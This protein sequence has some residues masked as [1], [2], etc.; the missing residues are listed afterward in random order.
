MAAHDWREKALAEY[1]G[2]LQRTYDL[3]GTEPS[4]GVAYGK[5]ADTIS[6]DR[7]KM[8]NL[9]T[10]IETLGILHTEINYNPMVNGKRQMGRQSTWQLMVPIEEARARIIEWDKEGE[11][12]EYEKRPGYAPKAPVGKGK[13]TTKPEVLPE[14]AAEYAENHVATDSLVAMVE[15]ESRF[16]EEPPVTIAKSEREETRAI[17]GPE[18]DKTFAALASLRKDEPAALV[19][20]ARQYS[21]RQNAVEKQYQ[22]LVTMGLEVDKEKFLSSISLPKDDLLDAISLVLPMI[23]TLQI[24]NDSLLTQLNTARDKIK[25]Y[26]EIK[27]NYERLQKRWNERVAERVA[28]A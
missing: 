10:L 16:L 2:V 28:N 9:K 13:Y 26:A 21:N 17:A 5:V 18:P 6:V 20:A 8:I 19:E 11:S 15:T 25:D 12:W 22:S 24:R 1:L 7:W 27:H 4:V 14:T 3:L 23:T